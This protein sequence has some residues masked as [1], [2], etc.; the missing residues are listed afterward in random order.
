MLKDIE[1]SQATS[2]HNKLMNEPPPNR[3]GFLI[4]VSSQ[5]PFNHWCDQALQ[6]MSAT[7]LTM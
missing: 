3:M 7:R 2:V 1:L 5:Q 6:K 4:K